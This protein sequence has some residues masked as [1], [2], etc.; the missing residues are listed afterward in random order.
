MNIYL[1]STDRHFEAKLQFIVKEE[2]HVL[3]ASYIG[4]PE[5]V[6]AITAGIIEGRTVVVEGKELT[7]GHDPFRRIERKV[8]IGDVAHAFIYNSLTTLDGLSGVI[9]SDKN[10]RGYILSLHGNIKEDVAQHMISRFGLPPEWSDHY[11]GLFGF[12]IEDLE[13]IQNP[14]FQ[15]LNPNLRALKINGSESDVLEVVEMA[16]K[17]RLLTIPESEIEGKFDPSWS[18]KEYMVNNASAMNKKLSVMR[19]LH[20]MKD[21]VDPAIATMS[22]VPFPAQTHVIQGLINGL[23]VENSVITSANMGTGK[24]IQAI[25]VAHVLNE[26]K[27]RRGSKRGTAVLLSAPG[28]TL[29]K[30]E[31]KEIG[32]T[33]PHAKTSIVRSSEDALRLL[34][35]VRNGY[36]PTVGDLEFTIVGIDKAK[37]DSEP[38]FAGIWKRVKNTSDSY[39][40]HCPDCGRQL[41]KKEEGE[42]FP[43][44]WSDVAFGS[45]PTIEQLI[46]AREEKALLPNGLLNSW[47]VKWRRSKQFFK[48]SYQEGVQGYL[49]DG[50]SPCGTKLYRPAVKSRGETNKRPVANIS[51]IFK[52]MKKYF[53]LYIVDEVHQCKASGSGRGDAFAQM[54]KSAK[55]TL[56]LTGTLVNGKSTSIKEI[57]WRTN[58]K[59]LLDK[60]MNDSTGDLTWAERYGKLKQIVYLQDEVNHQ[61]WVTRQRRKPMQPTEE[62]GIAP[63]MTAEFL[64]HKTAFL[65]LEDLGLPLV[66][67]K[68]K[69][70]FITP[71]PEHEAAYRQ[72][73]EVMYDECAKRARAGAKGAWSKFNPATLNYAARPDLGAFYTFVSVD[74]QETIVSAPQLTGYTAKEEWLIDNVKKE[75]SEGRGVVIY[76]NYT[77]E[78]Q[79]NERVHDILKENGIPSRILNESNTEKRSEVLQKFEDE[80]VK[81]IITNMKLVE[82]GLDC[83]TRSR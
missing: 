22:R 30:W 83:A 26:R 14:A 10:T 7:R 27:K 75:L 16:L 38:Y 23:D 46:D 42:W 43:L 8:G 61:G 56:M 81:V 44:D 73:H 77:G 72:F 69:P 45:A 3:A 49:P 67:L 78:Y 51:K 19:P 60:G 54:V 15:H 9:D 20:T 58:P 33:V 68:E 11:A 65:D 47:K 80:G 41:Y 50:A 40:W 76:N 55:K 66:E 39:G 62:P 13:V 1:Q 64:L 29:S 35:R 63:H 5:A 53:D 6:T 2:D 18:L 82:V 4:I 31:K 74:G 28:I 12:M 25:G 52:R 59:S 21:K 48:C 79:L 34:E 71:K 17:N 70:I 57:L 36:R 32:K 24:S 37:R